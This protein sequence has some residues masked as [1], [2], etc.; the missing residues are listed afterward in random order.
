MLA[1]LEHLDIVRNSEQPGSEKA[2]WSALG[3]HVILQNRL[4]DK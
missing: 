3:L 1:G 2:T 4:P